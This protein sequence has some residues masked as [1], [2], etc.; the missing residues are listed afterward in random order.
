MIAICEVYFSHIIII[1]VITSSPLP[2]CL[3]ICIN[4]VSISV[5]PP[6]LH[7]HKTD[8]VRTNLHGS[9]P[10]LPDCEEKLL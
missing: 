5:I 7:H 1:I 3:C 2:P 10:P 4:I 9:S 8:R 6:P